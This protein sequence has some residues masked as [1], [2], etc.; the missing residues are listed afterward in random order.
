MCNVSL[1]TRGIDAAV[2]LDKHI[3]RCGRRKSTV[4]NYITNDSDS[5]SYYQDNDYTSEDYD[6]IDEDNIVR[7]ASLDVHGSSRVLRCRHTDNEVIREVSYYDSDP[8]EEFKLDDDDD[9]DDDGGGGGGGDD[10]CDSNRYRNRN[11][12]QRSIHG[13]NRN[14]DRSIDRDRNRKPRVRARV[15]FVENR[16]ND[17]FIEE[18]R[19]NRNGRVKE[20]RQEVL[21]DWEESFYSKYIYIYLCILLYSK[22]MLL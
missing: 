16:E 9:D 4:S 5:D 20:D 7:E 3:D 12:R 13:R 10:I 2:V 15:G 22:N 14:R 17:D 21:D 8:E 1:E 18:R 6:G 19:I 11:N